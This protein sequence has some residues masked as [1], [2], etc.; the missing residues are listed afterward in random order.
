M[1]SHTPQTSAQTPQTRVPSASQGARAATKGA[2]RNAAERR[3]Q[4]GLFAYYRGEYG[5]AL[6]EFTKVSE[7]CLASDDHARYVEAC[8][9]LLRILAE[10]E[11]FA[12]IS[13]IETHVLD[14]VQTGELPARLKSRAMYILGIC[15][16]Y[17]DSRHDE[18]MNRFREAIDFAVSSDDK[19]ALASPLYGA[20]TI[21]YARGRYDEAVK[22]LTRL[23][24]LLSCLTMPELTSSAHLLRSMI[25]RKQGRLDEALEAAW[26]AYETLKH[27]PHLVIYLHT[28]ASL[29]TIYTLKG[30]IPCAKLYL[31]LADRSLRRDTFPRIGRIVD[32]ALAN[33]KKSSQ[34]DA[35]LS[36]ETRTGLLVSL[37]KGEIRFEGQFILRDLLRVFLEKPGQVF[38]K[39]DLA[40]LVWHESYKT[41]VHDN[42]IYVTIK[43]LRKLLEGDGPNGDVIL[44]AKTGYFLNPKVRVIIDGEPVQALREET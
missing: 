17:Q 1:P 4:Q 28:L 26:A 41:E 24:I 7:A 19:E 10:R 33:V 32:D 12:K 18:A 27:H 16:T 15:S 44:R 31:E 8:T 6:K 25:R 38:S 42:K 36:F 13:G 5:T 20:A 35:D 14:I 22:E 2:T 9:F 30:D 3:F 37:T 21:L 39:E 29:G 43:R 34:A 23:E 11:E 40:R